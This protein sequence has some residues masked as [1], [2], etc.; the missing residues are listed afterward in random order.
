MSE[1]SLV[2]GMNGFFLGVLWK[3]NKKFWQQID[4][5]L[6]QH[7]LFSLQKNIEEK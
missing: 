1:R 7:F 3:D 4:E 6:V 2:T 5:V